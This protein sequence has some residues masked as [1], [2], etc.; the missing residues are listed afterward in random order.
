MIMENNEIKNVIERVE[1]EKEYKKKILE[2]SKKKINKFDIF[3]NK[4]LILPKI[5]IPKIKFDNSNSST[6]KISRNYND[7]FYDLYKESIINRNL[8]EGVFNSYAFTERNENQKNEFKK[9]FLSPV[10]N[11]SR[12]KIYDAL[13]FDKFNSCYTTALRELN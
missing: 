3:H 4:N 10:V 9:K 12:S 7:N 5:K 2:N 11:K 6:N 8:Y 1:K 13:I